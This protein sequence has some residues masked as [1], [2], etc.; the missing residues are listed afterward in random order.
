VL[1][2]DAS[3]RLAA[4]RSDAAAG[5]VWLVGSDDDLLDLLA[6]TVARAHVAPTRLSPAEAL[7]RLAA[8]EPRLAIVDLASPVGPFVRVIDALKLRSLPVLVVT[9]RDHAVDAIAKPFSPSRLVDCLERA[10]P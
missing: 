9:A 4:G 1:D 5:D 6:V 7:A 10:L 2:I 8:D 3:P